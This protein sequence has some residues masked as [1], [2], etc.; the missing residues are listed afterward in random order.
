MKTD[1]L[2][3]PQTFEWKCNVLTYIIEKK[4]VNHKNIPYNQ[5]VSDICPGQ[6]SLSLSNFLRNLVKNNPKVP[7]HEY[8]T[9]YLSDPSP[10]TYLGNVTLAQSQL[11]YASEILKI[12]LD[13]VKKV[14]EAQEPREIKDARETKEA[15]MA[16]KVKAQ[17]NKVKAKTKDI[18]KL[19]PTAKARVKSK[20]AAD[21]D[22]EF[23]YPV[24]EF[25]LILPK[26][27][28]K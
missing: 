7:L 8:C 4:F 12:K 14:A 1:V 28:Y 19:K 26:Y 15:K 13:I 17:E 24:D 3:L 21:S 6:T 11:E 18:K 22:Q 16:K 23:Q 25:K 5:V 2:G 9:S 27:K 20:K 10:K